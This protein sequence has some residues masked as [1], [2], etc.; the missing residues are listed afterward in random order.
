LKNIFFLN[1]GEEGSRSKRQEGVDL[2]N[3]QGVRGNQEEGF[4]RGCGDFLGKYYNLAGG[5]KRVCSEDIK[6]MFAGVNLHSI[7][8]E[9]L[10]CQALSKLEINDNSCYELISLF[11]QLL[12]KHILV[13]FGGFGG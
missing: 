6:N 12:P 3:V 8:G 10:E 5:R 4:L 13:S 11:G 2:A 7:L 1:T 9:I